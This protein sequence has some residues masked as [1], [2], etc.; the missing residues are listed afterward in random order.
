MR[1]YIDTTKRDKVRVALKNDSKV[2]AQKEI[3][4]PFA[5]AEK[6]LSLIDKVLRENKIK[7]KDM[8]GIEVNN[9]GGSF[10]A[11]RVGVVT[12]NALG[13][14]LGIP[15]NDECRSAGWRTN[16]EFKKR[17]FDVVKPVYDKE[18]NITIKRVAH[19]L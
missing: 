16:D 9:E 14:A 19:N 10:T 1:L 4:A 13:Y 17:G 2:V 5:Q 18:P 12:A 11:L 7:L 6:L 3:F 15:V 8:K